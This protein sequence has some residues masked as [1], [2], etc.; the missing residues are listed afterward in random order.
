[1]MEDACGISRVETV[2]LGGY[3]QKIFLE[4]RRRDHPILIALHGDPGLPVPFCVGRRGLFPEITARYV[5]VCWVQY[6]CG[7]NNTVIDDGFTIADFTAMTV[8]LIRYLKQNFPDNKVFL[9][10]M[11]W[12]SIL[13]AQAVV[14]VPELR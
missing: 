13:S 8:D 11:S 6:G 7:I 4:G 10:G 9:F 2:V 12:G 14:A 5:L 1:M 3:R